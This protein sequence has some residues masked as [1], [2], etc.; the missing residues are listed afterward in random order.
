MS[1]HNK[2]NY[3]NNVIAEMAG[4]YKKYGNAVAL[5]GI[6]LKV[7]VGKILAILGPN[8]AG[9][10]T[11]ISLLLGLKKPNAGKVTLFGKSPL[12]L[13]ARRQ[14]GVMMQEVTLAPELRAWELI[15]LTASYY[16]HP[17]TVKEV[18]DLTNTSSL[19]RRPYGKMSGGQKRQVQFAM[20]LVGR[21]RLLFLDEPTAGMDIQAREMMWSMMRQLVREGTSIVLTTH[22][23]EEAEALADHVVV[24]AKGRVVVRGSVD[25]IRT[26]VA[27][28]QIYCL[29]KL[30]IDE[31]NN[32]PG[33]QGVRKD[34]QRLNITVIDAE[35]VVRRLFE[36]DNDLRELEVSRAGL[37]E[38][39]TKITQEDT[40]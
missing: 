32:W 5:D 23:L 34:K 7:P 35:D 14:A 4:V 9:K 27:R 1:D 6:D 17:L 18:M 2:K 3:Q 38:A 10:T 21:P 11:A 39:F 19:A 24:L 36:E 31:I 33:V 20:A 40:Q 8:G 29:T 12:L 22:Y 13:E 15:D 26:R 28:K 16:P 25:E 30:S 37:A